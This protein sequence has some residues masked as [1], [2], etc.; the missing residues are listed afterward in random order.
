MGNP[1]KG[2]GK[3]FTIYLS[4]ADEEE[5]SRTLENS[6]CRNKSE[7]GRKM[8]LG[9]PVTVYYRN[10]SYDNFTE[11]YVDFK[12]DLDIILEKGKFTD[13][14]RGWILEEIKSIKDIV[15]KLYDHVRASR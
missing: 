8:L 12:R 5:V 15:V 2:R 3:A 11:A 7:Y 13:E 6:N 9:K 4:L 14:E 10:Q 1:K